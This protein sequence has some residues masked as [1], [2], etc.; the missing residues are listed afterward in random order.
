MNRGRCC[1]SLLFYDDAMK[2]NNH[3]KAIVFNYV[4]QHLDEVIYLLRGK[5]LRHLRV[6]EIIVLVKK[7]PYSLFY[8]AQRK[9]A[10]KL[11]MVLSADS[12]ASMGFLFTQTLTM[13]VFEKRI[14]GN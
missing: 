8:D 7:S 2:K 14:E 5:K 9:N 3:I 12:K 13:N 11:W 6:S 10:I 1:L 4:Q